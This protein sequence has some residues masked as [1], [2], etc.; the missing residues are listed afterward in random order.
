MIGWSLR[1]KRRKYR[2]TLVVRRHETGKVL[3]TSLRKRSEL[4]HSMM[5]RLRVSQLGSSVCRMVFVSRLS[6]VRKTMER[7]SSTNMFQS[8]PLFFLQNNAETQLSHRTREASSSNGSRKTRL[9]P[10][11]KHRA[12]QWRAIRL[13]ATTSA[14]VRHT[15]VCFVIRW[16]FVEFS[17]ISLS[18]QRCHSSANRRFS[19]GSR[20]WD[21]G[22]NVY[23]CTCCNRLRHC[24]RI[25]IPFGM[26]SRSDKEV[27]S[28]KKVTKQSDDDD[29]EYDYITVPPDS[30]YAWVVLVA[31]FVSSRRWSSS[32][33]HLGSRWSSWSIWSSMAF[34]MPSVRYRN[35]W[36]RLTNV[37]N[38]RWHWWFP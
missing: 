37:T 19:N 23:I 20:I 15:K 31:C 11:F 18:M 25:E 7:F 30:G 22:G 38:G 4:R 17:S 3:Y 29:D 14:C 34:F 21:N 9:F 36:K 32:L 24:S 27:E 10:L 2:L 5:C 28:E 35:M 1:R 12:W 6:G 16:I 26:E 8:F 33:F 13:R